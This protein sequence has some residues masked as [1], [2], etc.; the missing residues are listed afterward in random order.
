[1][2]PSISDLVRPHLSSLRRFSRALN[3]S[4]ERGDAHIIAL[5]EAL[6]ANGRRFRRELAPR[7]SLFQLYI[8]LWNAAPTHQERGNVGHGPEE[9][10]DERIGTQEP[11]PR[12]AFL[13]A[14]VEDFSPDEIAQILEITEDDVRRLVNSGRSRRNKL[15]RSVSSIELVGRVPTNSRAM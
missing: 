13:L 7:I 11:G 12:Q 1:M 4:E 2:T 9:W 5:L 3:G 10:A 15:Q 14:A 6:V 8:Q